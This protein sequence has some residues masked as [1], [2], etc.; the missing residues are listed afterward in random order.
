MSLNLP[1][2]KK[3]GRLSVV[4]VILKKTSGI[5]FSI[6][7]PVA[8]V[9]KTLSEA[10]RGLRAMVNFIW[11]ATAS[12]LSRSALEKGVGLINSVAAP[13]VFPHDALP[14]AL[15]TRIM[16][17]RGFEMPM[18]PSVAAPREMRRYA[19]CGL[20]GVNHREMD[21]TPSGVS[22]ERKSFH[23][24]M[25]YKPFSVRENAPAAVAAHVSINEI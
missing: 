1:I 16:C 22:R 14:Q 20:P 12:I 24:S 7:F 9:A 3:N 17:C 13:P 21:T 19:S 8:R 10:S 5:T 11:R 23:A 25:V 2:W 6:F 15:R 4:G 18:R